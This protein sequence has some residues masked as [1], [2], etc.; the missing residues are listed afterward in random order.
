MSCDARI[1]RVDDKRDRELASDGQSRFG[2]Y[3]VQVA[4][5]F[6]GLEDLP[7]E[8]AVAALHTALPPTMSPGYV[9]HDLRVTDVTERWDDEGRLAIAVTVASRLPTHLERV[10]GRWRG[11][12]R[13]RELFGSEVR[14]S[15]PFDND[16]LVALPMVQLWVP[17]PV[18]SLPAPRYRAGAP[19]VTTAKNAV[20]TIVAL[21]NQHLAP[22]LDALGDSAQVA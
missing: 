2:A 16:R 14:W 10:C 18:E 13:E 1:F 3:L 21:L 11:W 12:L 4:S 20:K 17:V 7:A 19:D 6:T 8:F 15:E 9:S 5:R 22:V